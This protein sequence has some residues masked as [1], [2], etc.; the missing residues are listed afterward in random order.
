MAPAADTSG[1]AGRPLGRAVR[2]LTVLVAL[3]LSACASVPA[4]LT[5]VTNFDAERYLGR[6]YEIARYD[7]RFERGLSEVTADYQT[8]DD[9]KI[10]VINRGYQA[11]RDR[12]REARGRAKFIGERDVAHL[13][14]SFFGPFFSSY[15]VFELDPDYRYALVAGARRCCLWILAREPTLSPET[16][17]HLRQRILAEGFDP[18]ALIWVEQG[19]VPAPAAP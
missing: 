11:E 17:A 6:W 3:G 15:V 2:G 16:L 4:G 13:G 7:H 12:W 14:V 1:K 8:R 5:P 9:G 10:T 19:R 18:D